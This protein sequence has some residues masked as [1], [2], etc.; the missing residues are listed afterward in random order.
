MDKYE[1]VFEILE[2]PENYT[3]EKLTETLADAEVKEIYQLLCKTEYAINAVKEPDIAGEW[4]RFSR[5]RRSLRGF[6]NKFMVNRAAVIGI[7]VMSSLGA[8][9][10]GITL[11]NRNPDNNAVLVEDKYGD[12]KTGDNMVPESQTLQNEENNG[13]SKGIIEFENSPLREIMDSISVTYG[14]EVVF[15]KAEIAD[16][17]LYYRLNTTLPIMEV[18]GQLN[19]FEQI[20]IHHTD[21]T[22]TVE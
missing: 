5:N 15:R 7:I 11:S 1:L 10:V 22:L 13:V 17:H 6:L 4:E 8:I 16:L 9:A 12:K 19:T 3:S 20:N 18:I 21:K 14:V 2:H